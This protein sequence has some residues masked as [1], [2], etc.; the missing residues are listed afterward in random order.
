M[1]DFV[2]TIGMAVEKT[3]P[4]EALQINGE[5]IENVIDGY[6]TLYVT[7][8]ELTEAEITEIQI[9]DADGSDYYGKRHVQRVITVGYQMLSNS[10]ESFMSKFNELNRILDQEQAKLIFADEPDK[11]YIGTKSEVGEVGAGKLNVTGEFTFYCC[12]PYKYSVTEK[13]FSAITNE[14]GILEATIKNDGTADASISYTIEH[15]HENGYI[16]IV[17][18]GGAMQFGKIEE[19]DGETY[20]VNERLASFSD[21]FS[22]PDDHGKNVMHPNYSMTGSLINDYLSWAGTVLR[23]KSLSTISSG[24]WGGGMRTLTLPVDSEGEKGAQN[25]YSYMFFWYETGVMGQTGEISVA[26]LTEDDKLICGYNI[27]KSDKVGNNAVFEFWTAD[28]PNGPARQIKF[29][30]SKYDIDN[31]FNNGRGHCDIRKEGEKITFFW[32]GSYFSYIVPAAKNMKCAKIQVAFSQAYGRDLSGKMYLSR[33]YMKELYFVKLGVDKWRDIP[34]RYGEG[35]IFFIDGDEQKP[36]LNGLP[37]Q[38]DEIVGTKYFKAPP[39]ESKVEFYYSTF[40][41]VPPTVTVSI[42]E[43]WL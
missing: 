14:E 12:D 11:Y 2:D 28:K 3:L 16:G 35:S 19:A 20:K 43:R 29:I 40:C 37:I 4:S 41:S 27:I 9:G 39:G 34:N 13:T 5:Y 31:P 36:Y 23:L 32:Y 33:A 22:L 24:S 17:G 21:F 26:Y 38:R 42:R 25:F 15:N 6:R 10:P 18:Q 30:P 1:Y 8:R 7:G